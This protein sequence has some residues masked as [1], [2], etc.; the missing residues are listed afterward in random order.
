MHIIRFY[1]T[2]LTEGQWSYINK[3]FFENDCRKRKY[4]LRDIFEAILY[5]LVSG[6][7]WRML[8]HDCPHWESVYYYYKKWRLNGWVEDFMKKLVRKIRRKR[9]QSGSPTVGAL[10]AQSVKWGNHKSD[11]GFDGNKK[12]KGI[13]R[14]IIVDRNGYIL[15][16]KVS[17][18]GMH[19]VH[20][21]KP[22]CEDASNE[23]E[24]LKK[25]LVD[26]GYRGEIADDIRC[27]FNI[28]LEVSNTPNGAKGF[29]PKPLRWVVERTFAWLDRFRRLARNYEQLPE[30]SEEMIDFA[31]IKILLNQI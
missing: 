14:S 1:Q 30:S 28:E 18:A 21:V 11:N 7:Q 17:S 5:L 16:R 10:D 31:A 26:R 20:S 15:S 6:C 4:S 23:W 13:K 27:D 24:A 29:A 19:D 3:V 8:P 2:H 25:I 22:L 9:S 12:V